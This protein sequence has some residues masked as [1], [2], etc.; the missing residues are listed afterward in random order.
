MFFLQ[1]NFC[2]T[3][4]CISDDENTDPANL[5]VT[6]HELLE[7][8]EML[9][10]ILGYQS[11]FQTFKLRYFLNFIHFPFKIFMWKTNSR[12]LCHIYIYI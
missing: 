6:Y 2:D 9:K 10:M 3:M 5:P 11:R 1:E 7:H 12:D 4:I 8:L